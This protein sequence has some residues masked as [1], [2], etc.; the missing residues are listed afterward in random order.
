MNK[1]QAKEII[2]PGWYGLIDTVYAISNILGFAK[3]ISITMHHSMLQINFA[4]SL[5]KAE[6]YILNSIA[7]KIERESAKTCEQCGHVGVRR[8]LILNTPCLC[9]VCYTIRYN[10]IMESSSPQV[11]NQENQN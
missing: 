1:E 7:Y 3:I 8:K 6:Q 5:D 4:A 11:T 9:T 2:K 10:E